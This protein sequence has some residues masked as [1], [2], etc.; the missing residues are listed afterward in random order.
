MSIHIK[1][2]ISNS[3]HEK[4]IR[5]CQ[6]NHIKLRTTKLYPSKATTRRNQAG[7]RNLVDMQL[8]RIERETTKKMELTWE[9]IV[10]SSN[11][12]KAEVSNARK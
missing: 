5:A 2:E 6:G 4:I 9:S 3:W 1:K 7:G 12:V 8:S 10:A 11:Q